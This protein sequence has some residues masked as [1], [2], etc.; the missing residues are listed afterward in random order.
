MNPKNL[1]PIRSHK[2]LA[3]VQ[4]ILKGTATTIGEHFFPTLVENLAKAL[5]TYG[6]WVTIYLEKAQRLRALAFWLGG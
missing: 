3:A 5:G 2:E 6:A 4:A 1:S